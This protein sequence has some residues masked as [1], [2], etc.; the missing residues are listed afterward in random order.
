MVHWFDEL[1]CWHNVIIKLVCKETRRKREKNEVSTLHKGKR[2]VA[3]SQLVCKM[4][5]QKISELLN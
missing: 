1:F 4:M 2:C 3:Y 5:K